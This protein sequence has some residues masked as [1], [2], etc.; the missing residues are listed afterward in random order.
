MDESADKS[1]DAV[2]D[3]GD[4]VAREVAELMEMH[5]AR[6]NLLS[7]EVDLMRMISLQLVAIT[8]ELVAIRRLAEA[9]QIVA[10]KGPV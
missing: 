7:K 1:P 6:I 10:R 9:N 5:A 8:Q 3:P 4:P 2:S